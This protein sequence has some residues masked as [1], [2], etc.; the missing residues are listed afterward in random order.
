MSGV[1]ERYEERRNHRVPSKSIFHLFWVLLRLGNI[2]VSSKQVLTVFDR[3]WFIDS[4]SLVY[5]CT[6]YKYVIYDGTFFFFTWWLCV[7]PCLLIVS[8]THPVFL[9]F[10]FSRMTHWRQ[11]T[12]SP[13]SLWLD[14][15]IFSLVPNDEDTPPPLIFLCT[16]FQDTDFIKYRTNPTPKQFW[17][18][19]NRI[20]SRLFTTLLF[21]PVTRGPSSKWIVYN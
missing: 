4:C 21:S 12:L 8:V 15:I 7:L 11:Y 19:D 13:W 3:C 14:T 5:L 18:V 17:P 1:L 16:P 9:R 2:Q 6:S 20:L 10:V